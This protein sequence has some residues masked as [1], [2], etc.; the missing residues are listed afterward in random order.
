MLDYL[1]RLYEHLFWADARVLTLPEEALGER[2]RTLL[3]HLLSSEAV[4]LARLSG[5]DSQ[6]MQIWPTLCLAECAALAE[7]N[8]LGYATYLEAL[9]E[10]ALTEPIAYHNST[11]Q[12]FRTAPLDILTHVALH[13]SYHRGQIMQAVR[14]AGAEPVSTDYIVWERG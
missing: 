9:P 4:W 14:D 10:G 1:R 11:G 12:E 7:E 6:A 5:R 2:G 13:G 8:R 3:A